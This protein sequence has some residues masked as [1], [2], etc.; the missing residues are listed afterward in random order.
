MIGTRPAPG[1]R[2]GTEHAPGSCCIF[3]CPPLYFTAFRRKT[4]RNHGNRAADAVKFHFLFGFYNRFW[5]TGCRIRCFLCGIQ[6]RRFFS[7]RGGVSAGL[8]LYFLYL[9]GRLCSAGT[10]NVNAECALD[11]AAP[12]LPAR[13]QLYGFAAPQVYPF[14]H[15]VGRKRFL[16]RTANKIRSATIFCESNPVEPRAAVGKTSAFRKS[17]NKK[18]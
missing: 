12:E 17:A 11:P 6:H 2:C 4:W 10:R 18:G 16:F 1:R 7:R 8:M 13:Q 14:I 15:A 3:R 9:T 5:K